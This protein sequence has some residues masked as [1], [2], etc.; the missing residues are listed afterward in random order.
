MNV[1][2]GIALVVV[3]MILWMMPPVYVRAC[4]CC[5]ETGYYHSAAADLDE[6]PLSQLKRVRFGRT[7]SLFVNDAGL[8]ENA[9]G[10][11]NP[12]LSYPVQGA[13]ADKTM[14]LTL[15]AGRSS[16]KLVLQ[17]PA[18]MWDHSADIHDGK[19]GGG[20]GPLLYK[21]W[22]FEGDVTGTGI[23]QP[24]FT[25]PAKYVLV[26]QGRGNACDNAEDFTYWR[27]N[28]K[29]NGADYAF[30]GRLGKPVPA[31]TQ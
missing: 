27:L 24:G 20:G 9:L 31:A 14:T 1:R 7:A 15:G 12:Q 30:H 16:G 10:I 23:F 25:S 3:A 11:T 2:A 13:M 17:L 22:R 5:A 29:G 21:E 6:Y 28:V 18:K 19:L 4:A 26:L 8:E